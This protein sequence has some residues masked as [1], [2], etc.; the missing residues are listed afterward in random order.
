MTHS[1]E[2]FSTIPKQPEATSVSPLDQSG[3]SKN[4][5]FLE[6]RKRQRDLRILARLRELHGLSKKPKKAFNALNYVCTESGC[7]ELNGF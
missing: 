4:E 3:S 1:S 2:V 7:V 6:H 5:I